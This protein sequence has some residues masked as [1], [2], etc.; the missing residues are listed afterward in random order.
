ME[1][2]SIHDKEFETFGKVVDCPFFEL[3]EKFHHIQ[4]EMWY[5]NL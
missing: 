3:F 4:A 2:Y 1:I 5:N